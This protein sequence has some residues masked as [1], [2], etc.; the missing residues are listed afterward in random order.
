[1]SDESPATGN[2]HA[3]S[4]PIARAAIG[5]IVAGPV[6]VAAALAT[7]WSLVLVSTLFVAAGGV[8]GALT[9]REDDPREAAIDAM[10]PIGA[11]L[12]GAAI[13]WVILS[14]HVEQLPAVIGDHPAA[15]TFG[16]SVVGGTV[17]VVILIVRLR[18]GA[19]DSDGLQG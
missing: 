5:T 7:G 2:R 12:V 15:S 17:V 11:W 10:L 14:T 16:A 18:G 1:M 6:G 3:W 13:G 19:S 9:S 4:S 8:I